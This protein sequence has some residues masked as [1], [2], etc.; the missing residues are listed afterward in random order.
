MLASAIFKE[1]LKYLATGV[2]TIALRNGIEKA[3]DDNNPESNDTITYTATDGSTQAITVT[4]TGTDFTAATTITAAPS[5][6]TI[7]TTSMV[8]TTPAIAEER[9]S[10][11][12]GVR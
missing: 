8:F 9:P 5:R 7:T 2:N 6:A 12:N 11:A 1:G 3:V 10:C 4:I